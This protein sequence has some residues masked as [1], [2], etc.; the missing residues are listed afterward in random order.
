MNERKINF[1]N[2]KILI[3]GLGKSGISC[4]NF[5]K[6]NNNCTILDDN[7]KN[8]PTKFRKNLINISKLFNINFDFIVISPGIDIN[9][10]RISNYL[11]RNRS[12]IITE[13]DI[14]EISYPK[15]NKITITG[16]NG[17]ST[18]SKLL[19]D[20]LKRNKMDVRLTGNIG[21]PILM[22]KKIKKNT[23]FVIEASSY[24]LDY[25]K[26]F[27]SKYSMILNLSPDHLE[28][29]GT[30]KNYVN[31]K[32]KI[33]KS[34][35]KNDYTFIDSENKI[36]N[37]LVKK[38]QIKSKVIKIDYLKYEKYFRQIDN[39][40][41][42]NSSNKKNLCFIFDI[43]KILK[44]NFKTVI[45]TANKFKGLNFR[46]QIIYQSQKL[47]IIND[48]KSTSFS[49]TIPLLESY[50][51]IYW[52]LGGLAKKGDKFKLNKKYFSN[53]KAF[54]YGKDR[55]LLINSL[56]NKIICQSSLT[57]KKILKN[58]NINIKNDDRKKVILFSPCAASFDQFRNFEE[59]GKFFNGN[60]K[61][62]IKKVRT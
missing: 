20:L 54:V 3:Y 59:R 29:H 15:I 26:Y 39:I 51:N 18:T 13:L 46:Q 56:P 23:I 62:V 60:I 22:E 57:L 34:Q 49:S 38:K 8:I 45:N 35:T 41:F 58:L 53:I 30:F 7:I 11:T 33:I 4:F 12:K 1:K 55:N 19:H 28:R 25:S 21:Y 5:L 44:I 37:R 24:Q 31:A 40:Y 2:K 36:L 16:T 61:H 14:F 50:K 27:K 10:C 52:I 43:A 42:K 48:S 32:F 47:L 6:S 17:K 9:K